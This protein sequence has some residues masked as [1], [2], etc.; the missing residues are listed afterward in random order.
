MDKFI[1]PKNIYFGE[2][3]AQQI[4]EIIQELDARNLF[5]ITDEILK[6]LGLINDLLEILEEERIGYYLETDVKPEPTVLNGNKII[7]KIRQKDYDLVIGI[8]GGSVIDVAK[9][10]AVLAKHEGDVEDYLNIQGTREIKEPG[11]PKILIPTTSGTGAEVTDIAVFAL[12]NTKDVINHKY[13]LADYVIVDYSLTY[14][15]PKRVTASSGVD[16]LTHAI[17]AYTS[18]N[19]NDVTRFLS[20]IAIGKI[21]KNIRSAVFNLEDTE[22][23]KEMAIGSILAGLSFFNAGVAGVHALAYPLGGQFNIAHGESNAVLLPYVYDT[24]ATA[25]KEELGEIGEAME[26]E[27]IDQSLDQKVIDELLQLVKDVDLK[28]TLMEFGI[29]QSDI[30]KLVEE[31]LKQKRLLARSPKEL[32][33]DVIEDIYQKSYRG[34]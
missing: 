20:L 23:K 25:C 9:A 24:I 8:G 14:S 11:L 15:M 30:P 1:S 19:S 22:A 32:T 4:M 7:N 2:G 5:I 34:V 13:L 3:Y 29:E 12:E 26:I 16:A 21:T 18:K 10:S 6:D 17:E 31:A 28:T 27:S 33:R